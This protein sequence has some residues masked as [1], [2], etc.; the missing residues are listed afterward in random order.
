MVGMNIIAGNWDMTQIW[1]GLN[2]RKHIY[3]QQWPT[4]TA[5]TAPLTGHRLQNPKRTSKS[6]GNICK[7]EDNL[8]G[9]WRDAHLHPLM[10]VWYAKFR[11][12][13]V[14]DPLYWGRG[15]FLE[16][17]RARINRKR[18][19][20]G[21]KIHGWI[22]HDEPSSFLV[23]DSIKSGF[24]DLQDPDRIRSPQSSFSAKTR[25]VAGS[26]LCPTPVLDLDLDLVDRTRPIFFNGKM[27]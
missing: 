12:Q 6:F 13:I 5:L 27:R 19:L 1:N 22:R 23:L 4:M 16:N 25:S 2:G 15:K 20:R 8:D 7:Y 21:R 9:V 18:P 3:M 26:S 11:C 10:S 14:D 17:P 24:S